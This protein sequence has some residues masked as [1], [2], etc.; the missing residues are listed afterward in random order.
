MIKSNVFATALFFYIYTD[1]K[2]GLE[3]ALREI[4]ARKYGAKMEIVETCFVRCI[5]VRDPII[6][7]NPGFFLIWKKRRS[8]TA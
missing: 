4:E 7:F 5:D 6:V 3:D 1:V 8:I 2:D